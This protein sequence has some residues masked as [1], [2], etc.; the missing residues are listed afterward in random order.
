M[1]I[2]G[3]PSR[4]DLGLRMGAWAAVMVTYLTLWSAGPGWMTYWW[5]WLFVLLPVCLSALTWR[6]PGPGQERPA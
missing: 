6:Q 1:A 4:R 3:R 2:S 5:A